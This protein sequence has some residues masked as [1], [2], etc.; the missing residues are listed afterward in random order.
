LK[1]AHVAEVEKNTE[2]YNV[3]NKIS[4][5]LT[6]KMRNSIADIFFNTT[7]LCMKLQPVK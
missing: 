2:S 7:G 3:C 4:K 1:H 6:L 5:T